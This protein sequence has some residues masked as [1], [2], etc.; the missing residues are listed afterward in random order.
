ME[1]RLRDQPL[2]VPR[3]FEFGDETGARRENDPRAPGYTP[4]DDRLFRSHFQRANMRPG[5]SY[6]QMLPVYAFG[7]RAA[8]D[9]RYSGRSFDEVEP[10]LERGWNGD[11]ET[12]QGGEWGTV[13]DFARVGFERGRAVG[14]VDV[15]KEGMIGTTPNERASYADP[16]ADSMDPTAPHS[17]EQTLAWT[18]EPGNVGTDFAVDIPRGA[19]GA[20][21]RRDRAEERGRSKADDDREAGAS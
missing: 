2:G 14:F 10:E 15:A 7:Q 21:G 19:E 12:I 11:G 18:S 13:R 20:P 9:P 6:E 3:A 16:V 17:P 1:D 4:E 8:R 5:R